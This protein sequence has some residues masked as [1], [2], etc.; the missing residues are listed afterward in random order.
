MR[1]LRL[2]A[3]YG[4]MAIGFLI[5]LLPGPAGWPGIPPLLLGLLMALSASRPARRW[6]I[7]EARQDKLLFGRFRRWLRSQAKRRHAKR[8]GS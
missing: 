2:W 5:L 7:T 6:F 3:G 1:T 4:L 8:T